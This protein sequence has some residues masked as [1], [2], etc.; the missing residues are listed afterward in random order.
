[1][2]IFPEQYTSKLAVM[3][4][5]LDPVEGNVIKEIVSREL[6]NGAPLSDL[7]LEFDD[8]PLGKLC[9]YLAVLLTFVS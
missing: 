4:D 9:Y 7:F 1:M 8:E 5:A 6:L 2:D 3:Q